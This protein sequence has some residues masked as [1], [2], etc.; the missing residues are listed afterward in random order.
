MH[1]MR[2]IILFNT[3][4]DGEAIR[5]DI[6]KLH[7]LQRKKTAEKNKPIGNNPRKNKK[8]PTL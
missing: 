8:T 6:A 2:D 5:V 1:A 7:E 4:E 3:Y